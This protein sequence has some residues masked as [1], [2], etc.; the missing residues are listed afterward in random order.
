MIPLTIIQRAGLGIEKGLDLVEGQGAG[1]A[2]SGAALPT[3]SNAQIANYI[4]A[5]YWSDVGDGARSFNMGR[6]SSPPIP[7]ARANA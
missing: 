2:A 3:Y 4:R 1:G 7:K 5:G 6:W